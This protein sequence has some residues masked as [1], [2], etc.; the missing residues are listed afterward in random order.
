MKSGPKLFYDEFEF[1]QRHGPVQIIFTNRTVYCT[2]IG[3]NGAVY[4]FIYLFIHSFIHS[5]AFDSFI[6]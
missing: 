3:I 6:H 4:L 2:L 5:L 1:D